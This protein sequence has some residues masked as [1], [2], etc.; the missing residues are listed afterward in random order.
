M[1]G[2]NISPVNLDQDEAIQRKINQKTKPLG[3]LGILE[4]LATQIAR[5]Q[6]A[7]VLNITKP[8]MLVFVADHGIA[9]YGVSIAPKDVTRQ[10]VLNFLTGGA[11]INV[12]TRQLNLPL[13]VIDAGLFKPILNTE[14]ALASQI[15]DQRLGHGTQAFNLSPAMTKEDVDKG[16]EFAQKL[17]DKHHQNG[18]NLISLGEMGIG[19]TSSAAAIMAAL[20]KLKPEICVGRGTGIDDKSLLLKTE[21][22]KEAL[23]LHR[24]QFSSAH[25]IL[26]HLGGFEIVQM[27]GAILAASERKMLIVVDGFI[28]TAAAL[29]AV[30]MEPAC[31]DY[32]IFAHESEEQGHTIMLEHLKAQP[33]LQ[34]GL[35]LGEGTGAALALPLIEA[36]VNFYNQMA[37]FDS[38]SVTNVS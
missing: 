17:V 36:A 12:F 23:S 21:L 1:K 20:L 14:H 16:F 25:S 26:S 34:L 35:R 31:R 15:I 24:N 9:D 2:F 30:N 28:A 10:M 18:T 33:L 19:N 29:V 32:L 22:I 37:S 8:V 27:T 3:A 5:V 11:A 7:N 13:E 4:D 38:A 6:S